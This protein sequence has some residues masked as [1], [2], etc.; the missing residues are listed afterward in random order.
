MARDPK[1]FRVEVEPA[2]AEGEFEGGG[3]LVASIRGPGIRGITHARA[4]EI[5]QF[6]ESALNAANAAFS[7]K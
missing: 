5:A 2:I 6:L 4:I 3:V 1:V 7:G